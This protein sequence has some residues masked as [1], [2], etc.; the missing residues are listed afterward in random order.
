MNATTIQNVVTYNTTIAFDNP[1]LR[2]F[3]GMTAYASIPVATANN[4]VKIPNGALRFKPD[5]TDSQR[6][7]LYAKYGINDNTRA[8]RC[9]AQSQL[10]GG[11]RRAAAAERGWQRQATRLRAGGGAQAAAAGQAAGRRRRRAAEAARRRGW[12]RRAGGAVAAGWRQARTA[13]AQDTGIVWKLLPDKTLEPVQVRL[14][15]TD[16]TFTAML[17][18]SLKPGDDLVI[19][20]STGRTT[21]QASSRASPLG[22]P[23]RRTSRS[24]AQV[25][26]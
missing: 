17:S 20:Q 21:A 15:V 6:N 24:A 18:G 14:G 8:R 5:L 19:G 23:G 11:Q 10:R 25:L 2:L 4:V 3:P 16:F 7:S 13:S 1:D 9:G 22:G 26:V 12:R